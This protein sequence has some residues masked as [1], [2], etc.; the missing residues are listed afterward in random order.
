MYT[1]IPSSL[2]SMSITAAIFFR[3]ARSLRVSGE[4]IVSSTGQIITV[5]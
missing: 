2:C 1:R 4:G 3:L 5:L